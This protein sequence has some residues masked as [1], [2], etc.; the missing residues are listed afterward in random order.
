[1]IINQI[2]SSLA[3]K[4]LVF[5][6]QMKLALVHGKSM[7]RGS[8]KSCRTRLENNFTF[9]NLYSC[10]QF[11]QRQIAKKSVKDQL[12]LIN[13]LK[14]GFELFLVTQEQNFAKKNKVCKDLLT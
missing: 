11:F 5:S 3:A 14:V 10:K 7:S 13:I 6:N 12:H 4:A 9:G 1:M 8:T 2:T